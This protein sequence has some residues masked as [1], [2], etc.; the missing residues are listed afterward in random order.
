MDMHRRKALAMAALMLA[1]S[2]AD[3]EDRSAPPTA[4]SVTALPGITV[5]GNKDALMRSDQH[6]VLLKKGLPTLGTDRPPQVTYVERA[7]AYYDAH[8]DPNQLDV[9]EQETLLHLIGLDP[10]S[11]RPQLP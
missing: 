11:A 3:A 8:R 9:L 6:L 10:M 4:S 5:Q 1:L 7:A 2:A